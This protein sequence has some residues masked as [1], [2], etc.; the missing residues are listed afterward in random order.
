MKHPDRTVLLQLCFGAKAH[1][2]ASTVGAHSRK[3]KQ[4]TIKVTKSP[5][6]FHTQLTGVQLDP[7]L[8]KEE[9]G[10]LGLLE[11]YCSFSQEPLLSV[12]DARWRDKRKCSEVCISNISSIQRTTI[13]VQEIDLSGC[14]QCPFFFLC[15]YDGGRSLRVTV[16]SKQNHQWHLVKYQ[17]TKTQKV[18]W[19][20]WAFPGSS[21]WLLIN[22]A[23]GCQPISAG[24]SA[25][26]ILWNLCSIL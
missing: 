20:E 22:N 17:S 24:Y 4:P 25:I 11:G 9:A 26:W 1:Y 2:W 16:S 6:A 10:S 12:K 15:S 21:S 13:S 5:P 19:G 23:D 18:S 7:Q 14:L 3:E 8:R